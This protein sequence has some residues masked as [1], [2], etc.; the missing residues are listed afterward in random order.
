M[1]DLTVQDIN[2]GS[3]ET[4][5]AAGLFNIEAGEEPRFIDVTIRVRNASDHG[6]YVISSIRRL[7]YDSATGILTIG[8]QESGPVEAPGFVVTPPVIL[9]TF[10]L[11]PAKQSGTV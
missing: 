4:R 10:T 8:L 2:V 5:E 1:P 6:L 3:P 9:P 7:H 11:V